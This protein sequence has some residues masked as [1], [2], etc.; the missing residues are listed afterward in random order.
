M[1]DMI[2][3]FLKLSLGALRRSM[4]FNRGIIIST[5]RSFRINTPGYLKDQGR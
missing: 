4:S 2:C 1:S 5:V 3:P